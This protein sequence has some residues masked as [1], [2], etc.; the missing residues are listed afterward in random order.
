MSMDAL[1]AALADRYR[2]ERELGAGGMAT[3]YLAHDLK[4]D[5]QV[6]IKVLRPELA[7]VIGAERFLSEIKTTANLQH[8][9]ILPLFDS[10]AVRLSHPERSDPQDREV[11]GS[12][13]FLYYVMPFIEGESLR[14]RLDREKQLP[15]ADAVR[16]ATEVASALDYAHRRGIIHRDIKPENI[17]LHDGQALVADFGIAL[18]ASSAGSRMTETGMSLGTPHYMSPEQAM[19]ER[20]LDAR[21]DVYALGA[22]T[23]EM[24]IGDPPFTGSTAQAIVA[25]VMTEKP[26][27]P[28]R[29][30]DT[31]PEAVEDAV[32]TALQKLPAD[33]F[34]SAAEFSAA[35]KGGDTTTGRRTIAHRSA[36]PA[37]PTRFV[38]PAVAAIAA[39]V[40]AWGWL[41]TSPTSASAPVIR[42]R[43]A[44]DSIATNRDAMGQLAISPD[45][46]T[47][48]YAYGPNDRLMLRTRD[49]ESFQSVP[50]TEDSRSPFFSPDGLSLG[51]IIGDAV[52]VTPVSGGPRVTFTDSL[53]GAQSPSWGDDGYIY[54]IHREH[55][56][57]LMRMRASPGAPLEQFTT[58]DTA[59]NE[60]FHLFP[61]P[62]PDGR[63][64]LFTVQDA[65]RGY[66]I[67][68]AGPDGT[69]RTLFEGTRARYAPG[70]QLLFTT[71]DGSL[72]SVGLDTKAL[73]VQGDPVLVAS[74]LLPS[75]LGPS[76][77]DISTTGTLAYTSANPGAQ[78]EL[79]WVDR[80][81]RAESVD[82]TWRGDFSGPA[83]SPVGNRIA[84]AQ[85]ADGASDIWVKSSGEPPTRL[86]YGNRFNGNAAWHPSGRTVTYLSGEARVR[87]VW[88]RP[89]DGTAAPAQLVAIDRPISEITWT[90]SGTTLLVRTT[91]STA[92]AGDI[93]AFVPGDSGVSPV[94]DGPQEEYT[95]TFSPD[96][97]WLAYIS[98]ESGRFEVYVV[99]Y[100][101]TDGGRWQV[102]TDGG[103]MPRWSR[104]GG[105]IFYLDRNS[106]LV[107]TA[108]ATDG[109]VRVGRT[110]DL[111]NALPYSVDVVSRRNYDVDA[112]DQRFLMVRAVGGQANGYLVV[113][114]NWKAT[115][116]A[117]VALP[118]RP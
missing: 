75:L 101:A 1:R 59:E 67:A 4:H 9:H 12:P 81:G 77:F 110:T 100:P 83:F 56:G 78:R 53:A 117:A 31:I 25:K 85:R 112:T 11:E 103:M 54:G 114:E 82:T 29:A 14:D 49:A 57:G 33:R 39:V 70:D 24:L 55:R 116:P 27:P 95:P 93:L 73:T 115:G 19:G 23:Y 111:F 30:R 21:S 13:A 96:G 20:E 2:L 97:K 79:V 65:R 74:N 32:L 52:V 48:A 36:A 46:A 15:I 42:Y 91:T 37:G 28:S 113:T 72:W 90:P 47:L 35:L 84:V 66:L 76:D 98:P 99:P 34:A 86:T 60:V 63:G 71:A 118:P 68:I 87:D 62:M 106:R 94:M 105:E 6:A 18:A 38:W 44:L 22:M 102:S 50:G 7:A 107:A 3:V 61:D 26:V 92:G 10:G 69:H 41:R 109:G 64:V 16:L 58:V 108:I 43:V 5:R 88:T 40:G 80:R 8:P 104:G 45:G 89:M 51:L 17:L